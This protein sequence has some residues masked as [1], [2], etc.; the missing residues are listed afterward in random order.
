MGGAKLL[1]NYC[2]KTETRKY[3]AEM[4][5]AELLGTNQRVELFIGTFT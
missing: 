1:N 2:V 3:R 5:G 4:G